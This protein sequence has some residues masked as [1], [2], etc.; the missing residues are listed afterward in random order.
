MS[1]KYG[2]SRSINSI[3]GLLMLLADY[4]METLDSLLYVTTVSIISEY[5]RGQYE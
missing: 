2:K 1:S 3:E 5:C 4:L